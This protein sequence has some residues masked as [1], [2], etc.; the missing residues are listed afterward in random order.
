MK[1]DIQ[2]NSKKI[3]SGVNKLADMVSATMGAGG[4]LV[5]IDRKWH[6]VVA[7]KDGMT[8]ANAM[9]SDDP[10]EMT[11]IKLMQDM[12]R[13]VAERSGDGTTLATVL[14]RAFLSVGIEQIERSVPFYKV[15][16]LLKELTYDVLK[17][18][19]K[20][21]TPIKDSP[22]Q[23]KQIARISLNSDYELAEL[24]SQAV[25]AA[26]ENGSVSVESTNAL[27]SSLEVTKG[28]KIQSGYVSPYFVTD[29]EKMTCEFTDAVIAIVNKRIITMKEL[30]PL[31]EP[32]AND[33]RQIV[34][35]CSEID[36]DV[37]STLVTNRMKAGLK[38]CVV[39]A[40]MWG[41]GL[42]EVRDL[43]IVTGAEILGDRTD[44]NW[45]SIVC[46]S[47]R[48]VIVTKDSM[49]IIDGAGKK[50]AVEN[51]VAYYKSE[52]KALQE[53]KETKGSAISNIDQRIGA[54][55]GTVAVLKI[56]GLT[57]ASINEA[58]D[59]VD[60]AVAATRHAIEKGVVPGGGIALYDIFMG[61]QF[62]GKTENP[63]LE[64]LIAPA[65][66]IWANAGLNPNKALTVLGAYHSSTNEHP[67]ALPG[68]VSGV[69]FDVAYESP[70]K[71][72]GMRKIGIIDPASVVATSV[73]YAA[74][75]AIT[76]LNSCGSITEIDDDEQ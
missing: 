30:L 76:I 39:K 20:A 24:V 7:T 42:D 36:D 55:T 51:R 54:L 44:T 60:D 12:T 29:T 8:V 64:C 58:K 59:R 1:K 18:I 31:L 53:G 28:M 13:R 40:P 63:F 19:D 47:A 27:T 14:C 46:G 22:E 41:P 4:N 72:I 61:Y 73:K 70:Y 71:I 6:D 65:C 45:K 33:G 34:L 15:E 56:G 74:D 67:T 32:I 10:A 5:V 48:K 25:I 9:W 52:R 17:K 11:G 23:I 2:V 43:A 21:A 26:G 66:K 50:E 69:G 37:I 57:E 49:M 38:I 35:V 68:S 62:S 3:V 16:S 75:T